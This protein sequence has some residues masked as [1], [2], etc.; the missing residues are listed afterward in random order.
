MRIDYHTITRSYFVEGCKIFTENGRS[1]KSGVNLLIIPKVPSL[2]T[3]FQKRLIK[4][5]IPDPGNDESEMKKFVYDAG[6]A[7]ESFELEFDDKGMPRLILNH[8]QILKNWLSYVV[9][10]NSEYT[11]ER[12]ER[13]IGSISCDLTDEQKLLKIILNDFPVNELFGRDV[14]RIKFDSRT[15]TASREWAETA[16][17]VPLVFDQHCSVRITSRYDRLQ[18]KGIADP[19]KNRSRFRIFCKEHP[20]DPQDILSVEQ[21][22]VYRSFDLSYMPEGVESRFT[23]NGKTGCLYE[24]R[25]SLTV[26][27]KGL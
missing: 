10:L 6:K 3:N 15:N 22:T 25:I 27:E 12:V 2:F 8:K 18:I 20:F 5:T 14:Y 24:T 11:G 9:V 7:L 16:L 1:E 17:G 13:L 21:D 4:R 23:V 26:N 19:V